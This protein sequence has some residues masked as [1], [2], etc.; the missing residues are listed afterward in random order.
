[1]ATA[2]IPNALPSSSVGN[3]F[4]TIPRDTEIIMAAATPCN[5]LNIIKKYIDGDKLHKIEEIIKHAS[6]TR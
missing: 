6:P 4:F 1:M 5:A 2:Y 3:D